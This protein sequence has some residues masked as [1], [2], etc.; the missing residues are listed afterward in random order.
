MGEAEFPSIHFFGDKC[1]LG[2]GDYE[3]YSHS[4][5]KGHS[6]AT[7]EDTN[8]QL[9]KLFLKPHP[10]RKPKFGKVGKIKPEQKGLNLFLKCVKSAEAVEGSDIKET[11]CGDDTGCVVLSLRSDDHVGLCKPGALIRV[12]NSHVRM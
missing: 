1:E 11:V 2:G 9:N 4:R 8:Q 6:V 5:V 12:Q 7:W 3:I 10:L